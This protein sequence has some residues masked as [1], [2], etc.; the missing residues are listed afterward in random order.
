V[1]SVSNECFERQGQ[2]LETGLAE[3]CTAFPKALNLA[4][5]EEG[6]I[7]YHSFMMRKLS[8]GRYRESMCCKMGAI[9]QGWKERKV[10]IYLKG[11]GYYNEKGHL[12][13]FLS[14]SQG[15]YF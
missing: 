14:Y 2:I 6:K 9:F 7:A 8:G 1:E 10:N 13:E 11:V 15:F 4:F 12:R 3:I 5:F